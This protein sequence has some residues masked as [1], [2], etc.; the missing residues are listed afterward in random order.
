MTKLDG[1]PKK[2]ARGHPTSRTPQMRKVILNCMRLGFYRASACKIAGLGVGTLQRWEKDEPQFTLDIE[3]AS[4][5][6]PLNA[7]NQLR[8]KVDKGNLDAIKFTLARLSKEFSDK[9]EVTV[10]SPEERALEIRK[11]ILSLNESVPV[12]E[13]E[14]LDMDFDAYV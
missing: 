2:D 10:L 6:S 5:S 7:A 4:M 14:P 9:V 11:H 1:N 12:V 3:S 8:G 13:G